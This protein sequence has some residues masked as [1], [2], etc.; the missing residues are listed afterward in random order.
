MRNKFRALRKQGIVETENDINDSQE[1]IFREKRITKKQIDS[2][3]KM[4]GDGI[5]IRYKKFP[6]KEPPKIKYSGKGKREEVSI[7]DLS[8][9]HLGMVNKVFDSSVGKSVITYNEEIFYRELQNLQKAIFEIHEILSNSYVLRKLVILQLGDIVTNDRI[10]RG[11]Q[12]Q[13]E[14]PVGL[15]I[16]DALYYFPAFFNNLSKIYDE[17]EIVCVVGNHG[18]DT[19]SYQDSP[20]ENNF[21]WHIYKTWQKQFVGSKRINVIVPDTRRYIHKIYDWKHLIEHGDSFRGSSENYLKKQIKDIFI[22]V[23]GFDMLH[24]GHFHSL[25]ESELSDK[26]LIKR[27]ASWIEKDNYAFHKYK[28]YSTPKQLF[29]G[30]SEKRVQTWHYQIDLRG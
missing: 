13:I 12:F 18:R 1:V 30:C 23:G 11:Q 8:D 10:F 7:L 29:I 16:E 21:E 17:I 6:L 27:N 3:I 28:T 5:R 20:V 9:Q 15:Q 26:V 14:K 19:E 22:N 24:Y 25:N 4:V 2:L